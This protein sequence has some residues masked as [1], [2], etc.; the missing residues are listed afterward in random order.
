M[1][2]NKT[3]TATIAGG[4]CLLASA[5][6]SSAQEIPVG[7]ENQKPEKNIKLT[8]PV[9]NIEQLM[10]NIMKLDESIQGLEQIESD[11]VRMAAQAANSNTGV[12]AEEIL[13]ARDQIHQ[14]IEKMDSATI[15]LTKTQ[16]APIEPAQKPQQEPNDTVTRE[17]DKPLSDRSRWMLNFAIWA[18]TTAFI[19]R[20]QINALIILPFA[21]WSN[22][23]TAQFFDKLGVAP[24]GDGSLLNL[25]GKYRAAQSEPGSPLELAL[26]GAHY[27]EVGLSVLGDRLEANPD[28]LKVTLA[29]ARYVR[30]ALS[31][32]GIPIATGRI[33]GSPHDSA[34]LIEHV[35]N[36]RETNSARAVELEKRESALEETVESR[37]QTR[38]EAVLSQVKESL[39]TQ[40][41]TLKELEETID[42]R[43]DE[44]KSLESQKRDLE[45]H[46]RRVN[47]RI[48]QSNDLDKEIAQKNED[49]QK[50][51]GETKRVIERFNEFNELTGMGIE[52][53]I[54]R[55]LQD[56][57]ET[58]MLIALH[59]ESRLQASGN[60]SS[61]I[62]TATLPRLP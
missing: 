50:I 58:L 22:R 56:P 29:N 28:F 40:R 3:S 49:L 51:I 45:E 59:A 31:Q 48:A 25:G 18:T 21:Q 38:F 19:F 62:E 61:S 6:F 24:L 60:T 34:R 54:Q 14:L 15:D 46:K 17:E 41:T 52:D 47:E 10:P 55:L 44:L 9:D 33:K 2:Q 13:K 30:R 7:P 16:R 42:T 39:T 32:Y 43:R 8:A 26:R 1:H 11:F 35:N 23:Y 37:A 53:V 5:T 27:L 12:P 20:R 36:L 4:L 57:R